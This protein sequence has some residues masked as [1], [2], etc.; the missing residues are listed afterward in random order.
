M[1]MR[2]ALF[3]FLVLACGSNLEPIA[4]GSSDAGT[5]LAPTPTGVA[6]C[7][8]LPVGE[9]F[10]TCNL[11]ASTA[12]FGADEEAVYAA[13]ADGSILRIEKSS[14]IGRT[15]ARRA[16]QSTT[17]VGAAKT[18]SLHAGEVGYLDTS[19][20]E[21]TPNVVRMM[22]TD[23]SARPPVGHLN[24]S[25]R[26]ILTSEWACADG[27]FHE[28]LHSRVTR[29]LVRRTGRLVDPWAWGNLV[30]AETDRLAS[31]AGTYPGVTVSWMTRE[32]TLAPYPL[33]LAT[34]A[35]RVVLHPEAGPSWTAWY[36]GRSETST[37][38]LVREASRSMTRLATVPEALTVRGLHLDDALYVQTDEGEAGSLFAVS[39]ERPSDPIPTLGPEHRF[40]GPHREL[41]APVFDSRY[42]YFTI[43]VEGVAER[44]GIVRK[45][46]R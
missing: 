11:P 30:M 15:L 7:P 33:A 22:A 16:L 34:D 44:T 19:D 8:S 45:Q 35:E 4:Q 40:A 29:C 20:S 32:E 14:G 43:A 27:V 24:T 21:Y 42:V 18:A 28:E 17:A 37:R 38:V 41:T 23:G 3:S 26:L 46:K 25:G 13:S 9:V 10:V 1:H 36:V 6:G 39:K 5:T 12:L 2:I 31:V